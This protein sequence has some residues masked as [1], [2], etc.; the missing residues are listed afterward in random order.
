[1]TFVL[2]LGVRYKLII[3][4]ILFSQSFTLF[5]QE[6]RRARTGSSI[7]DDSS[8]VVY[9]PTT[10]E[11]TTV[12]NLSKGIFK[13][14][15]AD[16]AL[17]DY[18]RLFD[19]VD[20]S[21][22]LIQDLG[23]IGTGI[24]PMFFNMP[25][26]IGARSGYTLYDY[27]FPDPSQRKLF[28]TKSPHSWFTVFWGGKGR[29]VTNAGYT[30]NI[31][32]QWNF[33]FDVNAIYVDK[34]IGRLR[35]G[36]RNVESV[37]YN[38]YTWYQSKDKKYTGLAS[39]GRIKHQ[40]IE[41]G[42]VR[43]DS[44]NTPFVEYFDRN[45]DSNLQKARGKEYRNKFYIYQKYAF[46]NLF[47]VFHSIDI[48]RQ[49]N[50]FL[51]IPNSE[52]DFVINN[53]EFLPSRDTVS[54]KSWFKATSNKIG[55]QGNGKDFYY[56]LYYKARH[57]DQTYKYLYPFSNG[58]Q[59]GNREDYGGF[60]I[61]GDL[62]SLIY[63][64][65]QAEYLENGNY[66]A[67]VKIDSKYAGISFSRAIWDPS[68]IEQGYLGHYNYWVNDF[69]SVSGSDG[70]AYLNINAGPVKIKPRFRFQSIDNFTYFRDVS[71]IT[72]YDTALENLRKLKA[73]NPE[74]FLAR[75]NYKLLEEKISKEDT[76]INVIPVQDKNPITLTI[77][78]LDFEV[79]MF[80][81]YFKTSGNYTIFSREQ[82]HG[83][84]VPKVH[85][86]SRIGYQNIFF[87]GNLQ[88]QAGLD[89]HWQSTYYANGYSP[90]IQQFYVQR[91]TEVQDYWLMNAFANIKINRVRAFFKINNLRMLFNETGYL[92]TPY[93]PS[94]AALFDFGFNWDFY[95]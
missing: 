5:S 41:L 6:Q 40:V 31:N 62:D 71:L 46:T 8:K 85:I 38:F 79:T 66:K 95:D 76:I 81:V 61:G 27:Y 1:M 7:V 32:P 74:D 2:I 33:G 3:G 58:I 67:D 56:Q 50:E 59:T 11:Y 72:Q 37:N 88:L 19:P 73:A 51:I 52:P 39:Y 44:L 87:N 22:F 23:N 90:V 20:N 21:N 15:K 25:N 48:G 17:Y 12:D 55:V 63:A 57:I 47:G 35:R 82:D 14:N 9:S 84:A 75:L 36:D 64:D 28:N 77:P 60:R 34:L 10:T 92:T 24:R 42:G 29:A 78:G 93:Y 89:I 16:T 94:I 83:L 80:N 54:D 68:F 69:E 4:L 86:N 49:I 18:H 70:M 43:L 13:Y 91:R 65:I 30:R 45:V 53:I 26:V